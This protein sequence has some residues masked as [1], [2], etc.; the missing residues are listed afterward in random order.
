MDARSLGLTSE[1]FRTFS[2]RLVRWSLK[3]RHRGSIIQNGYSNLDV[4]ET[5]LAQPRFENPC[6]SGDREGHRAGPDNSR[7]VPDASGRCK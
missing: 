7:E 1:L 5:A 2:N 3:V 4:K 6:R